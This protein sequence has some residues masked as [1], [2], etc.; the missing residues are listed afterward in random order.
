MEKI[1]IYAF[2][3]A[4]GILFEYI[5]KRVRGDQS[6]NLK[7][8]A[9]KTDA[10]QPAAWQTMFSSAKSKIAP[11]LRIERMS[12]TRTDTSVKRQPRQ[13]DIPEPPKQFLPGEDFGEM[14]TPIEES[15][16]SEPMQE[17]NPP[18]NNA[19]HYARWRQAILDA[20]ILQ[21]KF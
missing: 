11:A 20:E 14:I 8:Q 15:P 9:K 3:I 7:N 4:I 18:G 21:R 1:I 2:I 5:K 19:E 16:M 6:P 13:D 10:P 12:E 17:T